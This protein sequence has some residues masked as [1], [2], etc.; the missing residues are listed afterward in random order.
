MGG[1]VDLDELASLVVSFLQ[2]S[3]KENPSGFSVRE[4]ERQFP[5]KSDE[6][7]DW[8]KR[9]KVPNTLGALELIKEHVIVA[10]DNYHGGSFVKLNP[11]SPLVD[12]HLVDLIVHQKESNKKRRA[13]SRPSQSDRARASFALNRQY[14]NHR[15]DGTASRLNQSNLYRHQNSHNSRLPPTPPTPRPTIYERDEPQTRAAPGDPRARSF[16]PPQI[17][18]P[19]PSSISSHKTSTSSQSTTTPAPS[20][21]IKPSIQSPCVKQQDTQD[22]PGLYQRKLYVRQRIVSML[23]RRCPEIK[24]LHVARLYQAEYDENLDPASLG[25]KNLSGLFTDPVMKEQIELGFRVPFYF[26]YAKATNGKENVAQNGSSGK[27]PDDDQPAEPHVVRTYSRHKL[28]AIDPFN[29]KTMLMSLQPITNIKEPDLKDKPVEDAVKY[30][31][32]R[33]IF[34]SAN[35]RLKLDDWERKYEQESR[36]KIR[37][38]DYGF[39]TLLEFFK[40]LA[41]EMPIKIRL[42]KNDDWYAELELEQLSVWLESQMEHEHYK[43]MWVMDSNYELAALPTDTYNFVGTNDLKPSNNYDPVMILSVTDATHMWI[44]MRTPKKIEE[45]LCIESGMTCYEDYKKQGLFMVHDYFIRPGFP[46]AVFEESQ[47]RWC[48]ALLIKTPPLPVQGN[49]EVTALL[50]DYGLVRKYPIERLT[51]LMKQHLRLP[52]GLIYSTLAGISRTEKAERLARIVLTE[53]TSPPVT[54]ACKVV[55]V[56]QA[57]EPKY[58]PSTLFEISLVDTRHGEDNNLAEEINLSV[59]VD[60]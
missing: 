37:I 45:H 60:D 39:K 52:V 32:L 36:L 26:I 13:P 11:R 23:N 57:N 6:P 49:D 50:V 2:G 54:L 7:R 53:Y 30:K 5:E 43:A 17:K 16:V 47:Q 48:R 44:Q 29:V 12:R 24:L 27:S 33:I 3:L 46:C 20:P 35:H 15:Y 55:G 1:E 58:L 10:H 56:L 14:A 21:T 51:C 25:H 59:Q 19:R 8:Y 38:R 34:R 28:E 9:Y 42:D 40:H 41:L 31:T 22:D 18:P 4:F